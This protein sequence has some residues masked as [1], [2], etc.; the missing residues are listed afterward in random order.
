MKLKVPTAR[1]RKIEEL[2]SDNA[3]LWFENVELK[4]KLQANENEISDLWYAI[5]TGGA[6]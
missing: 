5:I 2:E 3:E 1:D 4:S 6:E